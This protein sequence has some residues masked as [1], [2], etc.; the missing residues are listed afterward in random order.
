[1]RFFSAYGA[2]KAA[3]VSLA[4]CWYAETV[5]TGPRVMILS[6]PPMPTATRARFFPGEDKNALTS[7]DAVA[8]SILAAIG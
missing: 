8:R 1:V 3:Q 7:P 6:P 4:R 5:R 2:T